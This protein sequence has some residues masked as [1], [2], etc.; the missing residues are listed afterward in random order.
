MV[1][2]AILAHLLTDFPHVLQAEDYQS[3]LKLLKDFK[4]T[5]QHALHMKHFI[6]IINVMLSKEQELKL[7]STYI[8]ESYC[9]EHWHHIMELSFKQAATDKMQLENLDLM[10]IL[11]ENKVIVSHDFIKE[12]ISEV[13]KMSHIKKSNQSISLLISILR[14]VNIDMIENAA[15]LKMAVIKWLSAKAKLS[16]LKKV[17]ET[18]STVDKQLIS[19][20]YVLCV[21]SRQTNNNKRSHQMEQVNMQEDADVSEHKM[22]IADMVHNLQYRMLSKLIVSDNLECTKSNK[23]HLIE[24]LP[25]SKNDVK[26]FINETMFT[27]LENLIHDDN[28]NENINS[29]NET[30]LENFHSVATSLA[31]YVNILNALVG[32]ESIDSENF[33][34]YLEKR[35]FLK[36]GQLNAIVNNFN[37]TLNI[38]QNPN[39]VNEVVE[40]LLS[41][42]H[43]KYHT[44]I[45][46]NMFIVANN[47]SIIQWLTK[48]LTQNHREESL[49]LTP[50]QSI[51]QLNF[52]GKRKWRRA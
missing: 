5:I 31:T 18:G 42:W 49:V 15:T 25:E 33:Y 36:V 41:I 35:I 37:N 12:V 28:S 46:E 16:E 19:E 52:R 30:S 14:N 47:V 4:P 26:A 11:I 32:Y 13:T 48:Q 29:T 1:R 51:S 3:L 34:K 27:E 40:E 7:N 43:E 20:L 24:T 39:D 6:R 21:L 38:D 8:R 23:S 22:F 45:A 44:I 50:L 10:R 2:F 17:I 9:T